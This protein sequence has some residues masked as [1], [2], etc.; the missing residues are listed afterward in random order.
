MRYLSTH[1]LSYKLH[2][3][4]HMYSVLLSALLIGEMLLLVLIEF[5]CL[6]SA[7]SAQGHLRR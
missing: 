3:N 1:E 6:L 5:S 2:W 4:I 7:Y